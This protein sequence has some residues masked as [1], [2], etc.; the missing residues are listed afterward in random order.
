MKAPE[1]NQIL[2]DQFDR[3][4]DTLGAKAVEYADDTDRLRNF[5]LAAALTEATPREALAGMLV[6]HTV[7]IF[8]MC[9][10]GAEHPPAQW[11]EK[12]TDHINYLILLRAIVA[13]GNKS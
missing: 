6:K 12:I 4:R 13:E 1:F 11:D 9:L 5:K 2:N 7:S 10:D 8:D 3:C